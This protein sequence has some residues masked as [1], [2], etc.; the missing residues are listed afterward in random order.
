MP[1]E[2]PIRVTAQPLSP[3]EEAAARAGPLRTVR[4]REVKPPAPPETVARARLR[5]MLLGA[6]MTAAAGLALA[7][8]RWGWRRWRES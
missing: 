7:V 4:V 2:E 6:S 3:Q 5:G 1:T 8:A